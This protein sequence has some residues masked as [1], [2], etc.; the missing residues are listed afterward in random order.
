MLTGGLSAEGRVVQV[1]PG[2]GSAEVVSMPSAHAH[3]S[4][5]GS[6]R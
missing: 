1:G 5:Q 2:V 6:G 4:A 3:G